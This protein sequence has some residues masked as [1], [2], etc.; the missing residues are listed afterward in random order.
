MPTSTPWPSQAIDPSA[1]PDEALMDEEFARGM[2]TL[3]GQLPTEQASVL[4]MLRE[5]PAEEVAR[6]LGLTTQTVETRRHQGCQAL[7][8]LAAQM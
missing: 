6:T 2:D 1:R 8:R 4:A 3:I 7:R 5:K